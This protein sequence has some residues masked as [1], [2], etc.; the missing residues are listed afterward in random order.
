MDYQEITFPNRENLNS[1]ANFHNK[2]GELY[3]GMPVIC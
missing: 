1:L 2:G 3:D